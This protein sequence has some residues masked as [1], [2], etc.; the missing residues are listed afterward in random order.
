MSAIHISSRN[1]EEIN[2]IINSARER[3]SNILY[4]DAL[5]ILKL[6]GASV[7]NSYLA[8]NSQEIMIFS[9]QIEPPIVLKKIQYDR[10]P[11]SGIEI[12]KDLNSPI[13][14]LDVALGSAESIEGF[15]F[16]IQETA[17][18]DLK[19][20]IVA[21]ESELRVID[22]K[23]GIDI[24]LPPSLNVEELLAQRDTLKTFL[25]NATETEEYDIKALGMLL[26]IISSIRPLFDSI[27]KIEVSSMFLYREGLGYIITDAFIYLK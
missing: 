20:K 8:L 14:V 5:R 22:I 13:Q 4:Y 26:L 24:I 6:S 23:N 12:Y 17:P 1:K 19:L 9:S 25:F 27:S 18:K 3:G 11:D 7:I 2:K 15:V 16:V 21:D 10:L